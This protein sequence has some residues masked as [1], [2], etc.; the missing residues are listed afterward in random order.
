MSVLTMP[1]PTGWRDIRQTFSWAC[2]GMLGLFSWFIYL[3]IAAGVRGDYLSA[4]AILGFLSGLTAPIAG[5]GLIVFGR[6]STRVAHDEKGTT[7]LPDRCLNVFCLSGFVLLIP[8]CIVL[9]IFIPRGGIAI[10]MSR[11]WQVFSPYLFGMIAVIAACGLISAWNR[12]GVGHFTIT[13]SYIENADILSTK[14]VA[15]EDV[16]AVRDVADTAKAQNAIVLSL[17]NGSEQ[18]IQG[19]G[20]YVPHGAALY[21]MVQHYFRHPE[22]RPELTDGRAIDRLR[23]GLFD[24]DQQ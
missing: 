6:M 19:A 15:W 12:G 11:G 1:K 13:P 21:W 20:A 14:S 16:V 8:A 18:V 17:R 2:F 3:G 7:F 10:P 5:A 22:D 9:T 23:G 24:V 4:F